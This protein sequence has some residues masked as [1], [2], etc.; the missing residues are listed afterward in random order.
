VEGYSAILD[1]VAQ[2]D[3]G[4]S[5]GVGEGPDQVDLLDEAGVGPS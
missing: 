4:V 5:F 3:S 2:E 1:G